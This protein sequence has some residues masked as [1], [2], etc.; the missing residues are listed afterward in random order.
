M[1]REHVKIVSDASY[2]YK[3]KIGGYAFCILT[4]DFSERFWGSFE[5]S[6]SNPTEAELKSIIKSLTTLK[7]MQVEIGRLEIVTDCEFI[8]KFFSHSKG[9]N[10]IIKD[11]CNKIT[12]HLD[13]LDFTEIEFVHVKAHKENLESL[14]DHANNWCDKQSRLASEIAVNKYLK[15][16]N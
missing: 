14:N 12:E 3:T 6:I 11:L 1:S 7:N 2:H 15:S 5:D 9:K 4:K 10:S 8:A 13:D 16:L